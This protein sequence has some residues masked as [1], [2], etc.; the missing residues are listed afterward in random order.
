MA[1]MVGQALLAEQMG[2]LS[3]YL[4]LPGLFYSFKIP[5]TLEFCAAID[6]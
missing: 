6:S 4:F 2:N 1:P 3:F 5:M